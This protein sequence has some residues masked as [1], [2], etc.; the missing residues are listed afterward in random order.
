M[1]AWSQLGGAL[2]ATHDETASNA[3]SSLVWLLQ[4]MLAKTRICVV[5]NDVMHQYN[6]CYCITSTSWQG[7]ITG[8]V[9]VLY[10]SVQSRF[11]IPDQSAALVSWSSPVRKLYLTVAKAPMVL[12][13]AICELAQ[14][15]NCA[16]QSVNS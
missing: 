16:A 14:L 9:Q 15:I 8:L 12:L 11:Y 13:G 1:D 4:L 2:G 6:V 10:A 7:L 5:L 3:M